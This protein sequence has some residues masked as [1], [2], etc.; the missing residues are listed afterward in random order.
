[1][2]LGVFYLLSVWLSFGLGVAIPVMVLAEVNPDFS[3]INTV[4]FFLVCVIGGPLLVL[5]IF[6][7]A[8]MGVSDD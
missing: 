2:S 4:I 6:A 8:L 7:G 1:M 3:R 5:V